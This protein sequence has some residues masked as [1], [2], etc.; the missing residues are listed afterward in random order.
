MTAFSAAT[1]TGAAS[2]PETCEVD[3]MEMSPCD[4]VVIDPSSTP[5][6]TSESKWTT[7]TDDNGDT[8]TVR[9]DYFSD[10]VT[11]KRSR[12]YRNMKL[13]GPDESYF[14]SG[15]PD[16]VKWYRNGVEHGVEKR[17]DYESGELIVEKNYVDGKLHGPQR[18]Y[19]SSNVSAYVIHSN[20]NM[21]TLDGDYCETYTD[22]V[23]R[24]KGRYR[25]GMRTG[26]WSGNDRWLDGD[27]VRT[28]KIKDM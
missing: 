7:H 13:D 4:M 12:T 6:D 1:A 9:K 17:W 21:G 24:L 26:K 16:R 19:I 18:E 11:L 20:Y 28:R 25:N 3:I 22:G 14:T 8:V 27:T 15:K 10:G 2:P 23:I 5:E